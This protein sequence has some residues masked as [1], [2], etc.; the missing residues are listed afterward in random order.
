MVLKTDISWF[1]PQSMD[2][3]GSSWRSVGY[4]EVSLNLFESL[5]DKGQ[6]VLWNATGTKWHVNYCLPYYYQFDSPRVVGYTPWEY[7]A[8][9]PAWVYQLNRCE[10]VWA[11]SDWCKEIFEKYNLDVPVRVLAHGIGSEWSIEEREIGDKFY[12]LHVGGEILRKNVQLVVSAFLECFDGDEDYHLILKT[13]DSI[14][15]IPLQPSLKEIEE[16]PQIT[17]LKG[18]IPK[19]SLVSLYKN[20]HCMVYPTAG[21]G[22]GMIPFQAIATGMP[23]ICTELSGCS[24]F[25]DMS[26]PLKATWGDPPEHL[27]DFHNLVGTDAQEAIPDYEDLCRLMKKVTDEY[28]EQKAKA[29]RSARIIHQYE[30]WSHVADELL[31]FLEIS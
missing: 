19:D 29:M 5:K 8:I 21:E 23:T 1:T 22:F 7:T 31:D 3:T 11:T 20:S 17:V 27:I 14:E 6:R 2:A 18:H 26:M 30:T 15:N 16:H 4:T 24:Q 25:A 10:Q 9:P 12:F 13:L 28:Y